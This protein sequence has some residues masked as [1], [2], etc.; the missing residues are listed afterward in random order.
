MAGGVLVNAGR[1]SSVTPTVTPGDSPGAIGAPLPG[2][3]DCGVNRVRP[4]PGYVCSRCNRFIVGP[5]QP[6]R[7]LSLHQTP[8][9]G[10]NRRAF[11]GIVGRRPETRRERRMRYW[12]TRGSYA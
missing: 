2:R 3:C 1:L 10:A 8:R 4:L 11:T 6:H 12:L 5:P 7:D 9:R